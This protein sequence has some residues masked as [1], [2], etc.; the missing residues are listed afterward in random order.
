MF[1]LTPSRLQLHQ[2]HQRIQITEIRTFRL[3]IAS[4]PLS[5][6]EQFD[7]CFHYKSIPVPHH[8]QR[9][10]TVRVE[11]PASHITVHFLE[12][13]KTITAFNNHETYY[14]VTFAI[15]RFWCNIR[16]LGL[17]VPAQ[18]K[19]VKMLL[20]IRRTIKQRNKL[21]PPRACHL[22]ETKWFCLV[23]SSQQSAVVDCSEMS[24]YVNRIPVNKFTSRIRRKKRKHACVHIYTTPP[25]PPHCLLMFVFCLRAWAIWNSWCPAF[26]HSWSLHNCIFKCVL[27]KVSTQLAMLVL[28]PV[29][30]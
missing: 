3:S 23:M 16:H 6:M 26:F 28:P 7:V 21:H 10:S 12:D 17:R 2:S 29:F 15:A 20:W 9:Y 19:L 1:Y 25:A 24:F 13:K 30:A 5:S 27:S 11:L 18:W 22:G 8:V 14:C 4:S